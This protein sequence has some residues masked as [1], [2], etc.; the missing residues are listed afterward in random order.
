MAD[1]GFFFVRVPD[2]HVILLQN[3]AQHCHVSG[4]G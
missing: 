4:Q 2:L 3:A 1:Q